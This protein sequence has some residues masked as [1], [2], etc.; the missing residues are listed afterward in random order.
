MG[1]SKYL[2]GCTITMDEA[3]AMKLDKNT[4]KDPSSFLIYDRVTKPGTKGSN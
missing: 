2:D 3:K 1:N 4:N